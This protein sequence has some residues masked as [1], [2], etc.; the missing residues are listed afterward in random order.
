MTYEKDGRRPMGTLLQLEEYDLEQNVGPQQFRGDVELTPDQSDG[1]MAFQGWFKSTQK[2]QFEKKVFTFAGAAGSGK[3]TTIGRIAADICR[4]YKVAFCALTAMAAGVM[5]R[6]LKANGVEPAFCGTIH[7]MMYKPVINDKTGDVDSWDLKGSDEMEYDLIVVDEASML[8]S[9]LLKDMLQ[10]GKP[11][12]AVGDHYQLPPIGEDVGIMNNPDVRLENVHRQAMDNPIIVLSVAV[13]KGH[14]W[15]KFIR[16]SKDPRVQ[17]VDPFDLNSL[18]LDQFRG[19][20]T[21]PTELDPMVICAF[22]KTRSDI[23][24]TVRTLL[25]TDEKLL[26]GERITCLKNQYMTGTMLPNGAVGRVESLG[27]SPNPAWINV[28]AQFP[29][30]GLLLQ[31]G[32]ICKAQLGA[33]KAFKSF[34]EINQHYQSWKDVGMLFDYGYARTGHRAQGSQ[35]KTAIVRVENMGTADDFQRWIYTT[36]TRAYETLHACF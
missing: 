7:R 21:R 1:A 28:K 12:M 30:Q 16:Q 32:L 13:R 19:F 2:G 22:N 25:N 33:D 35:A 20:T 9:E 17:Y 11:I 18:L 23:N 26:P 34:A 24:K 14:D 27:Y 29:D 5:S 6:S 3:S 15:R 31:H 10:Y 36:F 4:N 8:S